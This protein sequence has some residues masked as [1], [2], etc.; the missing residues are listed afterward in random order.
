MNEVIVEKTSIGP[1]IITISVLTERATQ[2]AV[3]GSEEDKVPT[4]K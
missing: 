2:R 1:V 3:F 4:E